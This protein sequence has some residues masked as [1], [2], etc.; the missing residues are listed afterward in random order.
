MKFKSVA[1]KRSAWRS[2]RGF[3]L[4]ELMI[5]VAI[6]S[7]LSALAM[8]AYSG[9]VARAKRADARNQLLQ[10]AQ[11]MQQFYSANDSFSTDR[12][13][14]A[15]AIPQSLMQSPSGS[16]AVYVLTQTQNAAPAAPNYTLS[17][18]PVNPGPMAADSCGAFTVTSIGIR[19]IVVGGA[20][21]SS[22]QRD[23]CWK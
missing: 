14:A 1:A 8:Y 9:Y 22:D 20:A 5:V 10:A 16:A 12:T 18:T 15:V 2:A 23:I 6:I 19:G 3:T 17:M 21:G 11:F 7:V 4:I 13:G